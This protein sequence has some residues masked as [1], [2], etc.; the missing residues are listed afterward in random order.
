MLRA[1]SEGKSCE[2]SHRDAWALRAATVRE[3]FTSAASTLGIGVAAF[4]PR[5]RL[6]GEGVGV[7][8]L[9]SAQER[10]SL[11]RY[12]CFLRWI[13]TPSPPT[14]LPR[15]GGE[16]RKPRGAGFQPARRPHRDQAHGR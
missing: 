12:F 8:G 16:G 5:P 11:S 14:P 15:S 10:Q 1:T 9:G 4:S 2:I 6:G 13:L 7:R 3:R